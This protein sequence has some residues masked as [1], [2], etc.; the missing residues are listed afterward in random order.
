ALENI[1]DN[2]IVQ[3]QCIAEGDLPDENAQI[4]DVKASTLPVEIIEADG[5]LNVRGR[6]IAHII[7]IN[8]LG[9]IDCYD[10]TAE[11]VLP[12]HY[13]G[14]LCNTNSTFIP[15]VQSVTARKAG[16]EMQA[17]IVLSVQGLITT[18]VKATVIEH[19]E[20]L[21]ERQA[22]NSNIALRIYYAQAGEDIFDISKRYHVSPTVVSAINNTEQGVLQNK[23]QLLIPALN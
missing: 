1:V 15:S 18:R 21:N 5:E 3:V 17:N 10:K 16:A 14:S 8:A 12:K 11:Y 13:I 23:Q 7:C 4:I 22:A 19:V 2:F 6:A 9:E 20:M